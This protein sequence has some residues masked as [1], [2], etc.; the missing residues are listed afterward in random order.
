[1]KKKKRERGREGANSSVMDYV[2]IL[3]FYEKKLFKKKLKVV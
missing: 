1:M 2:I 3:Y